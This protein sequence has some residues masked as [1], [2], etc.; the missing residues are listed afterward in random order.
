MK[1]DCYIPPPGY[2]QSIIRQIWQ[3]D[4]VRGYSTEVIIPKGVVE[5][6]FD[7]GNAPVR[8]SLGSKIY[9]PRRCFINGINTSPVLL[10]LPQMQTYFGVQF[11]PAAIKG[12]FGAP[13]R[14]FGNCIVQLELIDP[15][16]GQLWQQIVEK[17]G[18]EER[19]AVCIPWSASVSLL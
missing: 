7:C 4:G 3:T 14:E 9:T 16:F 8:A 11:H 2:L 13:A 17:Q 1:N 5:I 6:I 12:L 19:V 18:F 15:F 10:Q